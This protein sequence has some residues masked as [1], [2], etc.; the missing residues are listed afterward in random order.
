MGLFTP[1]DPAGSISDHR[2]SALGKRIAQAFWFSS[3]YRKDTHPTPSIKS[4]GRA[5]AVLSE[6]SRS[7]MS[8]SLWPP[9]LRPARL[10]SPWDFPGENTG[11][12]CHALLQGI[13]PTQ[14]QTQVSHTAG[15]FT[16]RASRE[17]QGCWSGQPVSSP[18]DPSD[19]GIEPGS[20]A[21]QADSSPV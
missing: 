4:I 8:D 15:F 7:V 11:V 3:A 6:P 2:R 20:P 17:A 5:T 9:G 18:G 14:D 13:F 16:T 1:G 10:L 21:L 12:G 19:P